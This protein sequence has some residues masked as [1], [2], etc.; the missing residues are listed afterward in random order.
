MEQELHVPMRYK[1]K[2]ALD[3]MVG[4]ITCD[5]DAVV[6]AYGPSNVYS[7]FALLV[8]AGNPIDLGKATERAAKLGG[9]AD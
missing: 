1:G 4:Y 3:E 6:L 5:L 2:A 9:H 8:L 7:G